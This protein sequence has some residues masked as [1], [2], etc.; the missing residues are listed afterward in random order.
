MYKLLAVS[1][2]YSQA[3]VPLVQ[4]TKPKMTTSPRDLVR[5]VCALQIPS[6][7]TFS[8]DGRLLVYSA[9]LAIEQREG[10]YRASAIWLAATGAPNSARR[11]SR[12]GKGGKDTLK[13]HSPRWRPGTTPAI[14]WIRERPGTGE[15]DR[16]ITDVVSA[17]LSKLQDAVTSKGDAEHEEGLRT[18]FAG[19]EGGVSRFEFSP[20]NGNNLLCLCT[21]RRRPPKPSSEDDHWE[22]VEPPNVW[23]EKKDIDQ[24]WLADLADGD[25]GDA[26]GPSPHRQKKLISPPNRH[27]IDFSWSRDGSAVVI[28][29]ADNSVFE[30]MFLHGVQFDVV[31]IFDEQGKIATSLRTI[32]TFPS[33]PQNVLWAADS[34]VYFKAGIPAERCCNGQGLYAFDA[35]IS[36]SSAG[37]ELVGF[38]QE[39]DVMDVQLGGGEVVVQVDHGVESRLILVDGRKVLLRQAKAITSFAAAFITDSDDLALA[40]TVSDTNHPSEICSTAASGGALVKLSDHGAH[41][42]DQVFG[43]SEFLTCQSTDGE[44]SLDAIF[45]T[46]ASKAKSDAPREPLP[47]VVYIHGGPTVRNTD[48]FN[49]ANFMCAPYLLSLGYAILSPNYRGS[50]GKGTDFAS[51]AYEGTGRL[52][53]ADVIAL[54]DH[55]V[56]QGLA[57]PHRLVVAGWSQGGYLSYI[58]AVRNGLHGFGWRFAAAIPGAGIVD[59]DAMT[60]ISDLGASIETELIG[61]SAPWRVHKD[62]LRGRQGSALW[63]F[64][65]AIE[66][67]KGSKPAIAPMLMLHGEADARVPVAQAWGMRRALSEQGLEFECVTYPDQPHDIRR[68][69]YWVDIALRVGAWCERWIGDG[70]SNPT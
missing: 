70:A 15:D 35:G 8:S 38:G 54:T 64:R 18:L 29:H 13:D 62:S 63:E 5:A 67:A 21:D 49:I 40:V 12:V 30:E 36:S 37:Y 11:I 16:E 59:W 17:P 32:G 23:G 60:L 26:E 9:A 27:V 33:Y 50:T 66:S 34:R 58:C 3:S 47:T 14:A 69:A 1:S 6:S 55:A 39:E 7:P 20:T 42:R 28:V 41:F 31:K 25:A 57:D 61:G 48:A 65:A 53:Y 10:K 22:A 45:I 24:L 44:V 51:A 2:P 4:K 68:T 46:P 56:K 19:P 43:H 52:D